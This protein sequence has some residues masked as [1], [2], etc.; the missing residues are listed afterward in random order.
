VITLDHLSKICPSTSQVRLFNFLAPLN[1]AMEEFEINTPLRQAAFLAQVAHESGSFRYVQEI[2][3]GKAYE[4]RKD[5][6]NVFPGDGVKFKGRGLIQITGRA[7]Y[8]QCSDALG[9]DFTCHPELLEYPDYACRSAA[10]FWVSR[11]LNELA[12]EKELLKIS[13]RINGRNKEGLP[14]GW[15]ERQRYYAIAEQCLAA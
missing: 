9:T 11:G 15:E 2:A 3:S 13:I 12:D 7:N 6:G 1:E 10:W 8:A 14:N 5:L 4:G